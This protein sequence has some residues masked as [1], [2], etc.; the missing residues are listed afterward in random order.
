MIALENRKQAFRCSVSEELSKARL[1]TGIRT[2]NVHVRD[3]S[4]EGYTI[5]A[6]PAIAKRIPNKPILLEF[7]GETTL[8]EANGTYQD[9]PGVVR[10]NLAR[11]ADCTKYSVPSSWWSIFVPKVSVNSDP[12]LPVGMIIAF[13]VLSTCLPGTGDSLGTAPKVRW[14]LSNL[15][16]IFDET[17]VRNLF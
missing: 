12:T 9:E 16:Q 10:I 14:M 6:T 3:T 15:W 11:L 8:V 7:N 17:I 2:L 1:K 4:R 5:V 13:L